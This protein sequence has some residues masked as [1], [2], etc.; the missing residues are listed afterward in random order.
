[1]NSV[2][3]NEINLMMVAQ[4]SDIGT[5]LS[6]RGEKGVQKFK[7]KLK[8][9]KTSK[10]FSQHGMTVTARGKKENYISCQKKKV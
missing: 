7:K 5:V 2:R 1:M 3:L 9:I 4:Y 6:S 8:L 10:H